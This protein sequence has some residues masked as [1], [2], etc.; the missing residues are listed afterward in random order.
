MATKLRFGTNDTLGVIRDTL[1]LRIESAG[2]NRLVAVL[3]TR[4][5]LIVWDRRKDADA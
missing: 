2:E 1:A 3:A 5:L 4:R